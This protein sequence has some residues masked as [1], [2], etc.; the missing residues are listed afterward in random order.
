MV[1]KFNSWFRGARRICNDSDSLYQLDGF[2]KTRYSRRKNQEGLL[3][4]ASRE[5]HENKQVYFATVFDG[6]TPY[7]FLECNQGYFYVGFLDDKLRVY[8]DYIFDELSSNKLFLKEV[9]IFEFDNNEI[10]K[11]TDYKFT[12]NGDFRIIVYENN[13]QETLTAQEPLSS[14]IVEHLWVDYPTFGQYDELIKLD[15]I[16]SEVFGK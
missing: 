5:A 10:I 12:P 2:N 8:L 3:E 14:K 11:R 13:E 9:S 6:E 7:C 16:P 15:R 1:V 4:V